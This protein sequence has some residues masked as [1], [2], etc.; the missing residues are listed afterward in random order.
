MNYLHLKLVSGDEVLGENLGYDQGVLTIKNPL[1]VTK[2]VS[3]EGGILYTLKGYCLGQYDGETND[4]GDYPDFLFSFMK[5][6]IL[7]TTPL[8]NPLLKKQYDATLEYLQTEKSP[9]SYWNSMDEME[10]D[11]DG[12]SDDGF[13]NI[14]PIDRGR[15]N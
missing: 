8:V 15:L 2:M 6:G 7:G 1:V 11:S 3:Q 12:D 14:I 13:G 4:D 5:S 9:Y 10:A